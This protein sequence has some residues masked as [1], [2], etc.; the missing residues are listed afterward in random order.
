M[1][2][3]DGTG[4]Q[5]WEIVWSSQSVSLRG[6]IHRDASLRTKELAGAISPLTPL[7]TYTQNHLQEAVKHRAWLPNLLTGSPTLPVL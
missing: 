4:E 6:S 2:A 5:S 7:V 1:G 3:V